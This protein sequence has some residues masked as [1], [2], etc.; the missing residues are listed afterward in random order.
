MERPPKLAEFDREFMTTYVIANNK[1]ST[2]QTKKVILRAAIVPFFGE[3]RLDEIGSREIERFKSKLLDQELKKKS[4]NNYL[5]VLR[6]MLTLAVEWNLLSHVP[7]VKWFKRPPSEFD[8]LDFSE[9]ERLIAAADEDSRPMIVTALKTGMRL[10]ELLAVRWEDVDLVAGRIMVRRAVARGIVGTPKSGRTREIPLSEDLL[11]VLK[12]H[13]HLPAHECWRGR[14]AA[15]AMPL[16][17]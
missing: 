16:L 15:A 4:I 10:G 14:G 11:R 13:R 17:R 6:R 5:S 2:L 3:M 7:P 9:A 8:F 12:A 1:P